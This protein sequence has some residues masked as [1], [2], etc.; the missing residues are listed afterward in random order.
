MPAQPTPLRPPVDPARDHVQGPDDAPATLVEYGDYQ[1]V[2]CRRAHAGIRRLQ[3]ERLPG[4][5]RYVFR[6]FPNTRLHPDAQRAAEAAEAAAAQGRFWDMHGHLFE[7]QDALDYDSLVNAADALGLDR[8]RFARE[9]ADHTHAKRVQADFDHARASGA[10]A[11]PT[12]FVNG[13]RYDG[14]WDEE[15]VLEAM[16]EPLGWKVRQLAQDFAG[17]SASAGFLMLLAAVIALVW[18]NSPWAAGYTALWETQ[19]SLSL[20]DFALPMSL[21]HW[22]N[23]GLI[24]IFFFVVALE[25]K[26]EITAGEMSEPRRAVLPLAA[27]IGGMLA[28]AGAYL[29][30]NAGGRQAMGWGVPMATDTAFALGLLAMLGSRVP[31]ALKVFVA[32]LAIADDVG[33][34]LVLALFYTEHIA[35]TGLAV[36]ALCFAGALAL[37][38]AR[39]YRPWP[40]ALI[41]VAL[42]ASILYSGL[43]PTLAGV[44]LAFAIP[45][46]SPPRTTELHGQSTALFHSLETPPAGRRD[47]SR[48]QAVV[49]GLEAMVDRLL[50]PAQRLERDLRPWSSYLVLP[51]FALA[52]AGIALHAG[53]LDLLRPVSLGII[54]GLVLGKPL[55]ITVGAW[56]AVRTG[57]ADAPSDFTW[58]QLAG[59][60]AL[61]G[62]GFTMSIFIADAAFSDP[63][64]LS[65]AKLSVMLAC[66]LAAAIGWPLLSGAERPSEQRTPAEQRPAPPQT[67]RRTKTGCGR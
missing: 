37:N 52:N 38:R 47:E 19:M 35:L 26:R 32:T 45:T 44:L 15:S 61:C 57:L 1:C 22:V 60:G 29:L 11:T 7:H 9:L 67:E 27:A 21:H 66:V 62:I 42:W 6:H 25:I 54:L 5:M 24:V 64:T 17:L 23:D 59:A 55:G 10:H 50:S 2:Y 49:R 51:L 58:R 4:Q 36:A 43:H 31:P 34:I 33:A 39:V 41:G 65:L 40:Y 16:Q 8:P 48:Y 12:F 14:P 56:L 3:N 18:A 20:G 46:R 28:P 63:A 13:R 53:V 30:F